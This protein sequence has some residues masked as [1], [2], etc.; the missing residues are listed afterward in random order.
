MAL[1]PNKSMNTGGEAGVLPLRRTEEE[2]PIMST[3]SWSDPISFRAFGPF[4]ATTLGSGGPKSYPQ[5]SV[6]PD[7]P[8]LLDPSLSLFL[9]LFRKPLS[10]QSQV[11]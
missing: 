3:G 7:A 9:E 2:V 1:Y 11:S 6:I 10:C 4:S 8:S 5:F